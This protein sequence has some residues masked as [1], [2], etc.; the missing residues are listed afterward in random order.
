MLFRSRDLINKPVKIETFAA[1]NP[2]G[3][4]TV[5][6]FSDSFITFENRPGEL[7][8]MPWTSIVRISIDYGAISEVGGWFDTPHQDE[9]FGVA[10]RSL[11][12][13]ERG[14]RV[15][16]PEDKIDEL[17]LEAERTFRSLQRRLPDCK[18]FL[19]KLRERALAATVGSLDSDQDSTVTGGPIDSANYRRAAAHY[20][21]MKSALSGRKPEDEVVPS[22]LGTALH[23]GNALAKYPA[24]AELRAWF[25]EAESVRKKLSGDVLK[26]YDLE[27]SFVPGDVAL[28]SN[29]YS[30]NE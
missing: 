5:F 26:T 19:L 14:R 22:I 30:D 10:R 4:M 27:S 9:A 3:W 17:A 2:G 8:V 16:L 23:A 6:D 24:H 28:T 13:A 18:A 7:V 11:F 21:A 25:N 15:S 12:E 20:K 1:P 29:L